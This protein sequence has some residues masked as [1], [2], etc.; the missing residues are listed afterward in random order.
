MADP[1]LLPERLDA[2]TA[3]GV[4]RALSAN[5]EPDDVHVDARNTAHM[6]A[7]GAQVLLSAQQTAQ[8]VGRTFSLLNVQ[9]RARDQLHLMGLS[10]LL[11]PE[12]EE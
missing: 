10:K 2:A 1:V 11:M 9:E 8:S 3:A 6:G 5:A 4:A 7:M 12:D